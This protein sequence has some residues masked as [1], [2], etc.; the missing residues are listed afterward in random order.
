MAMKN[1]ETENGNPIAVFIAAFFIEGIIPSLM[2]NILTSKLNTRVRPYV[3]DRIAKNHSASN[4]EDECVITLALGLQKWNSLQENGI[5][6]IKTP[7]MN[8]KDI[9][10]PCCL[11]QDE[12]AVLV[13]F[14]KVSH[15]TKFILCC[16]FFY[17]L[18]KNAL[19]H[20]SCVCKCKHKTVYPPDY[21]HNDFMAALGT[22][23]V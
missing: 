14:Y 16:L 5:S 18:F 23:G 13:E 6:E 22:H 21:H 1:F 3:D 9:S 2:K 12:N 11:S 10:K 15:L 19:F 4:S 7:I 17:A 20:S 8:S